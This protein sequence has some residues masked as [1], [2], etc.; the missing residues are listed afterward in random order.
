MENVLYALLG[1]IHHVSYDS[2]FY[3]L[4]SL[5][6]ALQLSDDPASAERVYRRALSLATTQQAHAI[7][8]NLGDLYRQQKRFEHAKTVFTKSLELCPGYAPSHNNFG[9]VFVAE[10]RWNEAKNCF[11]KALQ[12][13]PL[14]D[15]AKSNLMKVETMCK[16]DR[17]TA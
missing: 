11:E 17:E 8:S 7:L 10:G 16:M 2:R 9:L 12:S 3:G 5:G 13:D 4:S 14:L 1:G 6:I 15:A